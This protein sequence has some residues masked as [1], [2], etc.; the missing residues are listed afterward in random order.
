LSAPQAGRMV[1][2]CSRITEGCK[3]TTDCRTSSASTSDGE[4]LSP[5][6]AQSTRTRMLA[7]RRRSSYSIVKQPGHVCL[8]N[9]THRPVVCP[10]PGRAGLLVRCRPLSP[11]RGVRNAGRFTAPAAPCAFAHGGHML[12][13][14]MWLREPLEGHTAMAACLRQPATEAGNHLRSA[15]DGLI[16]LQLPAAPRPW[17]LD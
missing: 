13:Q 15:R 14:G 17:R 5:L 12:F 1:E 11:A 9:V 3:Q 8:A 4:T 2:I 6:G 7:T 10:A 16:G